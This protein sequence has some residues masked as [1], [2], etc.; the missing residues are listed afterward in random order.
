MENGR[1]SLCEVAAGL[2]NLEIKLFPAL[3]RLSEGEAHSMLEVISKAMKGTLRQDD[4]D[5]SPLKPVLV[6]SAV[7][8]VCI[9]QNVAGLPFWRAFP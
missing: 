5:L 4:I 8:K 1:H 2:R 7:P 9:R 6:D 3:L